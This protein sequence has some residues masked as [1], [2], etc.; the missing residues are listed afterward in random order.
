MKRLFEARF[1]LGM[2]DPPD[3]VPYSK[4]PF[5]ANDSP[6]HRRL[7]LDAARESIVLLKNENHTLPLGKGLKSIAVIGPNADDVQVMLG[8]YNGQPS[9]ATTPLQGIRQHVSPQTKVLYAIGATLTDVSVV[10]VP[11]SALRGPEGERGL[12]AEFFA[13]KNLEGAPVLKRSD[14]A[15]NF[16]WGM[17][18]P[19]PGVPAASM[20]ELIRIGRPG[21]AQQQ[22]LGLDHR[23]SHSGSMIERSNSITTSSR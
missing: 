7:A 18:N 4:I 21:Q 15:E 12:R 11:A 23:I 22:A 20:A 3:I 9:R 14:E 19:A 5:T 13:N 8:N 16:D 6:E 17:L 2:F 10:P 1:R